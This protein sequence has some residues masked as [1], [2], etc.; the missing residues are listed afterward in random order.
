MEGPR[1]S[2]IDPEILRRECEAAN[3]KKGRDNVVERP[4]MSSTYYAGEGVALPLENEENTL[5]EISLMATVISILGDEDG[6]FPGDIIELSVEE[7]KVSEDV[8][9]APSIFYF[10]LVQKSFIYFVEVAN[11]YRF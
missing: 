10:I 4:R 7:E 11:A 5:D 2:K 6:G 1:E 3:A 8:P 9:C